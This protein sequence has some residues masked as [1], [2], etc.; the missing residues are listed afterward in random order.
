MAH[1]RVTTVRRGNKTYKYAQI[2][3]SFHR[4]GKSPGQRV[5]QNLGKLSE[6]E[7][8]NWRAALEATRTGKTLVV[9]G[10]PRS[11]GPSEKPRANLRY[12]DIAVLH[13]QWN[14]WGLTELLDELMPVRDSLVAPSAVVE[15]LVLQRCVKPNPK[16][17][18]VDWF[19]TTALPELLGLPPTHFNNTRLHRVLEELDS[20][21]P[22]LMRRLPRLYNEL[23]GEFV[24]MFLDVTDSWF[25]GKGCSL[26]EKAKT[27]EG[28][29][30]RKINIGLLCNEHGYPIRWEVFP[31]RRHDSKMM[32]EFFRRIDGLSWASDTPVICDRAMGCT[33]HIRKL[34]RMGV[35]FLTALTRR[36]F[37]SYTD[38]LPG[39]ELLDFEL[40]EGD[41]PTE[42]DVKRAA[43][44]IEDSGMEK[45]ADD[46]YLL[47]LK[48]V[49]YAGDKEG[50]ATGVDE[51]VDGPDE[52]ADKTVE[53]MWYGQKMYE[54]LD[55]GRA[56]NYRSAGAPY[57][58]EKFQVS[59]FVKLVKLTEDLQQR[60][61]AGEAVGLSVNSMVLLAKLDEAEQR[62]EFTRL[63]AQAA[64]RPDNRRTRIVAP[65][66]RQKKSECRAQTDEPLKVRAV[67][68]F[69]P[70]L[71]VQMRTT[72][73]K[74]LAN[75][76]TFE[77]ELNK[78]IAKPQSTRGPNQIYAEV[79]A[80]LKKHDAVEAF[81][82]DIA[83]HQ[84]N[85]RDRYQVKLT[86]NSENWKRRRRLD[87]FCMLVGHPD[88]KPNA[89]TLCRLYREK[90]T[91]EADFKVIKSVFEL[92]PFHHRTDPKVRAHV[93]ICMLALLLDRT[94]NRRLKNVRS[95]FRSKSALDVLDDCRLNLFDASASMPAHYSI[96]YTDKQQNAV[97][98][99]LRLKH[100]ADD[101]EL[102]DRITPR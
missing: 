75:I 28:R 60:V 15:S 71:F 25:V 31:G 26:A 82:I 63:V 48:T 9:A 4:P 57:G 86:L 11:G 73:R 77:Q 39:A 32:L 92:R 8:E 101:Q 89:A 72:A 10:D 88:L 84:L 59:R 67:I 81:Q 30:E 40:T 102:A 83:S 96:T 69:N 44:Q 95:K 24:A 64:A 55:D 97:L 2:V 17:Y 62:A 13:E 56:T 78:S 34:S 14:R 36:E 37:G 100:L 94:L 90:D 53:A 29:F 27:K 45:V 20:I 66:K 93:T 87:G 47:D 61:L 18:A 91:V 35:H 7:I 70:E 42:Q 74:T 49:V 3:Q 19:P 33:A 58:L 98:R 21:G 43:K 51:I 79:H 12:L 16:Y 80:K 50:Q 99:A 1:L 52:A 46:L 41:E 23:D 6:K 85:G 22:T 54:A 65:R 38:V 68:Y 76:R 5:I